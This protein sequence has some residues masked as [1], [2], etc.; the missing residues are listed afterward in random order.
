MNFF[1]V[2][3]LLVGLVLTCVILMVGNLVVTAF[4][5]ALGLTWMG[6]DIGRT[7]NNWSDR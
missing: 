5:L 1:S 7:I 4:F 2:L 3:G 6:T